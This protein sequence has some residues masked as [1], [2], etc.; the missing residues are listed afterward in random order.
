MRSSALA[1]LAVEYGL[2]GKLLFPDA[3]Q[4][5]SIRSPIALMPKSTR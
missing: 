1:L 2:N 5:R 4:S 3:D